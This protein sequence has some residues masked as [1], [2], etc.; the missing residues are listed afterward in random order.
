MLTVGCLLLVLHAVC[1]LLTAAEGRRLERRGA[2]DEA[3][4]TRALDVAPLKVSVQPSRPS[5]RPP[6]ALCAY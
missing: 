5:N 1:C 3:V 4:T 6:I 2:A